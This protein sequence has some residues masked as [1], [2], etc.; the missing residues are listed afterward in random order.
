[1]RL[2][3]QLV[4]TLARTLSP[5]L[6]FGDSKLARGI[7]GRRHADE[8]LVTWGRTLRDPERPTVWLHAPSVGE[9][10]QARAVKD[11]L[12][13]SHPELQVVFTYFSPSA[14]R[15]ADTFGAD[16][17]TYLPWDL[18]GPLA[19][20]LDA[21]QP[22]AVV[23]TKTEAWPVLV[24]E[25]RRRKIP[26]AIVGATVPDGSG[27]SRWPARTVMRRTWASMALACALSEADGERLADLGV[28]VEGV[29]VTGDPGIDSAADRFD[30]APRDAP[31]L[32]LLRV[33][34]RPT[35]VAGS[36]WPPDEKGLLPA[37]RRVR[38][39][40]PGLRIVIAPHEPTPSHV[41]G[42]LERFRD[43]GWRGSTLSEL[44]ERGT[45]E[46]SDAVVVDRIGVLA[47]LYDVATASY[48]GGGFHDDGLH[49]V[50]EPAAA[51]SP[52]VFGPRHQ[53]ARA[54]ADLVEAG[55][56]KI[57]ADSDELADVLLE[58]LRD[59]EARKGWGRAAG[60]Y[61]SKHRGAARRTAEHLADL[62]KSSA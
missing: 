13:Q 5:L 17:A 49:S 34:R 24:A 54:A 8:K 14:E 52:V 2:L 53:N 32:T 25:A 58:W 37:L 38:E 61:I 35:I 16:V 28:P 46:D 22:R 29:R 33:D 10:L 59:P 7:R 11:A 36:T 60:D 56:A 50:L 48:V 20:C 30:Q 47:H 23:F 6:A 39:E 27:R 55:G 31:H 18:R 3:Y 45:A 12:V 51:G 26:T 21:V 57:A 4:V 42:L 62:M 1:V 40:L 43:G 19:R 9:G 15:L 44:E 41:A